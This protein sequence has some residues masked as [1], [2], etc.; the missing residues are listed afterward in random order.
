MPLPEKLPG[1][2]STIDKT[3]P[4]TITGAPRIINDKVIIGN[5][6]A[7]YGVRGYVTAYDTATG[8]QAW[9]FYTVPGQSRVNLLSHLQWEDAA[10]TWTGSLVDDGRWR[11]RLG[12]NGLRPGA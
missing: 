5:G 10:K 4:Y 12:F 8:E 2:V 3:K 11:N 9:R 1:D 6:G 7:E